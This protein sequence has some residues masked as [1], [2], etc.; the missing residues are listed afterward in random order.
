MTG[1]QGGIKPGNRVGGKEGHKE[2]RRW[3]NKGEGVMQLAQ[4]KGGPDGRKAARPLL[5][6]SPDTELCSGTSRL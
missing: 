3:E 2:R 6:V 4:H 1:S 5:S